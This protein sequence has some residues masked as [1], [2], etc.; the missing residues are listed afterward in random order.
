MVKIGPNERCLC[1]SGKKYKRCCGDP[2]AATTTTTTT[3]T[4]QDRAS[5]HRRLDQWLGIFAK[6]D[7]REAAEALW[8]PFIHRIRELP[9]ELTAVSLDVAQAWAAFDYIG[10]R[11]VPLADV[12]LAEA[13]LGAGE[14][15]FL[16]ALGSSSMR[17][18]EV[19]D[20]APG[21]SLTLC[22]VIEGD[23][24]TVNERTASRTLGRNEHV[25]ARIVPRGPSGG[26]ELEAGMLHV[27]RLIRHAVVEQLRERRARFLGE[28]RGASVDSFYKTMPPFFHDVWVGAFLEP[29]VPELRTT[30]GEV[31][32]QTSV[33]LDVL[34]GDSLRRALDAAPELE[35]VVAPEGEAAGEVWEWSG[36]NREGDPILLGHAL[37][38][39]D[40]L[41]LRTHSVERAAR[42]R[43]LLEALA[44]DSLRHRT[45][46][47]EDVQHTLQHLLRERG[48]DGGG[49][50]P[51]ATAPPDELP[52]EVTEPLLLDYYA[53][54][55]RAWIDQPIPALDGATP[56]QAAADL[57]RRARVTALIDE[58][59]GHYQQALRRREPAYD[60]SWMWA[61]LG[62]EDREAVRHP[63]PL[64]YERVAPAV[65]G[66][67]ELARG[68]AERL[69][70][71]PGF[72]DAATVLS[73]AA[74]A[75]D[76]EFQRFVR[77]GG[78]AA[79]PYLRLMT[80]FE[81]HRRKTF[82]VDEPLAYLL[83]QTELD[84]TGRELRVPFAAFALVFTDRHVLS[85]AERLLARC[86][87]C[88]LSGH[89]LRI[90]TVHVEEHRHGDARSL[91]LCF[92][93]D[94]LG[95]D[96]PALISHEI[97]LVDGA[98]VQSYLDAVAPLP[99]IDPP[100]PDTSPLRGLLRTAINAVLYATSASITPE[101][102]SPPEPLEQPAA[103]GRVARPAFSSESVY[104][105]PGTIDITRIRKL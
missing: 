60:P 26:P 29:Y 61:E 64:V 25:A 55:Y 65:A 105:L 4:A 48:P 63:P 84:V 23:R 44:G 53:T 94:A 2:R 80:D 18:Y 85:L 77:A 71:D 56:R 24:I 5:A 99:V 51:G 91:E 14:R 78:G 3:Y 54:H 1:G 34:D 43:A 27:P 50:E 22:D 95:A 28:H 31:L 46:S 45:T 32:V 104:F 75:A 82:W 12:F 30:D 52:P 36:A 13:E 83:D 41:V 93:L 90:A 76:L 73:P 35:R 74:A 70:R 7:L 86:T 16:T 8:G 39:G 98:R 81:L 87:D 17:L 19:T 38:R 6:A 47:H 88:P 49:D 20:A 59:V 9:E 58:L 62:L 102:R 100:P 66:S 15:A 89:L 67:G 96:L 69:R 10:D 101:R 79:A 72:E 40:V 68:L 57:A 103:R 42:G 92:A 21:I 11:G 97:P 33:E 37:R